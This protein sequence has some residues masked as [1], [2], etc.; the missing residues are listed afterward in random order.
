MSTRRS[1]AIEAPPRSSAGSFFGLFAFA[2]ALVSASATTT[3]AT[4]DALR[5][6]LGDRI[7]RDLTVS[8]P[9]ALY[10]STP[11]S[12]RGGGARPRPR[13]FIM[14]TR[15]DPTRAVVFDLERGLLR[16]DEGNAR[17]NVPLALVQRLLEAAG[18]AAARDFG[19]GLGADLGRRIGERLGAARETASTEV[20]VEHLG[21][22]LA[23]LGLGNLRAE[24]W[25]KALVLRVA[26]LPRETEGLVGAILEG[27]LL[28]AF[29]RRSRAVPFVEESGVAFLVTSEGRGDFVAGLR[30]EGRGLG[31]VLNE[32]HRNHGAKA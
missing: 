32:L 28:R 31:A 30:A 3:A 21:G 29:G 15:F 20:W 14:T 27:A 26:D 7:A 12:P 4:K 25:G 18:P 16:D 23:L 10:F 2:L 6:H 22:H 8:A 9:P 24:R 19:H 11:M 1:G 17:L 5:G 13:N